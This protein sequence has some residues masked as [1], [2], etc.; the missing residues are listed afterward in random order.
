MFGGLIKRFD[1]RL[2]FLFFL[3]AWC[4]DAIAHLLKRPRCTARLQLIIC[5]STSNWFIKPSQND[6]QLDH[7]LKQNN[8]AKTKGLEK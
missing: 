1:A 3:S 5:F 7:L 2:Y 8:L 6:E 4:F